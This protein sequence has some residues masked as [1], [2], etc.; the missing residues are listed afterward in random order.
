MAYICP[1]CGTVHRECGFCGRMIGCGQPQPFT[2]G[3]LVSADSD[4]VTLIPAGSDTPGTES[5]QAFAGRY[6]G[7]ALL[8][9]AGPEALTD[10]DASTRGTGK[11]P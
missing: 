3:L 10:P 7:E 1:K 6:S 11:T 5:A 4:S 2:L 9:K 8:L